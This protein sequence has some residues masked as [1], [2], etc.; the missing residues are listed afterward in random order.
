MSNVVDNETQKLLADGSEFV[1]LERT[2]KKVE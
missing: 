1:I 2:G